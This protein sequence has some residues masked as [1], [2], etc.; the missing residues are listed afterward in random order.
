LS[1]TGMA[2]IELMTK[3]VS[4]LNVANARVFM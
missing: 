4:R 1:H 3:L 2:P